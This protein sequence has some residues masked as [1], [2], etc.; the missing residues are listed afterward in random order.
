MK[1]GVWQRVSLALRAD[2]LGASPENE[3]IMKRMGRMFCGKAPRDD[4]VAMEMLRHAGEETKRLVCDIVRAHWRQ[5]G[6]AEAGR[7][8]E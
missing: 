1:E 5:A 8:G 6:D 7:E 4:E 2:W 3:E